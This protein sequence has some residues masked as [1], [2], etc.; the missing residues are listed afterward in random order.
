M[1]ATQ[2]RIAVCILLCLV[3]IPIGLAWRMAPLGLSPFLFKYGG[4]VLWAIA[5]YWFIAAFVPDRNTRTL[6]IIAATVAALLELTR[7]WHTPFTDAF[8]LT[9][10]GRLLLGRVFSLKNI[11]AYWLAVALAALLDHF[12]RPGRSGE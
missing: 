10:P 3:T 8:R 4:S 1:T 11:A 7:L 12:L 9:L 2:R 6:A 5:L